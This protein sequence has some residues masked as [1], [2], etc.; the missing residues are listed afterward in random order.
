MNLMLKSVLISI[1]VSLFG[2]FLGI[3]V[4][5]MID[6]FFQGPTAPHLCLPP[7]VAHMSPACFIST[8]LFSSNCI[9]FAFISSG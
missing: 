4:T 6:H 7:L 3:L 8:D 1:P 2:S 5:V 9:H